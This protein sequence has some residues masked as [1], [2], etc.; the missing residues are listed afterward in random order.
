MKSKLQDGD[1]C[2]LENGLKCPFIKNIILL[3]SIDDSGYFCHIKMIRYNEDLRRNDNETQLDIIRVT[4]N[5][6]TIWRRDEPIDINKMA[7]VL[8]NGITYPIAT[9]EN[10]KVLVDKISELE[11]EISNLKQGR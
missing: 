8:I 2:T 6:E 4:R 7:T 5:G 11:K 10:M 9:H 1:F 3:T